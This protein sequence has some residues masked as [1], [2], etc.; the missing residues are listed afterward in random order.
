MRKRIQ[1]APDEVLEAIQEVVERELE[2]RKAAQ[3]GSEH[4]E[5]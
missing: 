5:S 3:Q 1:D 4:G 2:R